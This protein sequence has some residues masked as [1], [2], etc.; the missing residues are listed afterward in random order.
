[1]EKAQVKREVTDTYLKEI[2]NE[3]I[4]KK[5]NKAVL[6]GKSRTEVSAFYYEHSSEMLARIGRAYGY[7]VELYVPLTPFGKYKI[8]IEW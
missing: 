1:M 2:W 8:N 6:K 3:K 7:S 5:I 4:E